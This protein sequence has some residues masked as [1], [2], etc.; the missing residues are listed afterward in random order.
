MNEKEMKA[1]TVIMNNSVHRS[2]SDFWKV[3]SSGGDKVYSV[4]RWSSNDLRCDCPG[5][6]HYVKCKH[7][8]AV[9]KMLDIAKN[10]G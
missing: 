5:F 2:G 3:K 8:D 10:N 7:T 6:R 9:R 1:W 4:I